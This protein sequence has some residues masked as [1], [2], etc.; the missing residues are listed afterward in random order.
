MIQIIRI[1]NI[2]V[3]CFFRISNIR[4]P[5]FVIKPASYLIEWAYRVVFSHFGICQP[6]MLT[7]ARIRYVTLNRTFSCNKAVEELSYKPIVTLQVLNLNSFSIIFIVFSICNSFFY[8]K[9]SYTFNF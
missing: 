8:L 5:T 2:Y 1:A 6:Q 7:P 3:E 9:C 4:I